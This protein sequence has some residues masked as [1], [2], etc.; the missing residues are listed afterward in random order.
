[1][2]EDHRQ[3]PNRVL[4]Q[5]GFSQTLDQLIRP[6]ARRELLEARL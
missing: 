2:R 6:P 5:I 1:V 3:G 4:G